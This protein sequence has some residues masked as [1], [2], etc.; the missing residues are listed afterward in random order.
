MLW[1][2]RMMD[3]YGKKEVVG[4]GVSSMMKVVFEIMAGDVIEAASVTERARR[5]H[6][7][8]G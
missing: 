4:G 2:L 6:S 3:R 8:D 7:R 5:R 1:Q